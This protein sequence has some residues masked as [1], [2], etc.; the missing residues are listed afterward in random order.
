MRLKTILL[1]TTAVIV[2]V[3]AGVV[4][5]QVLGPQAAV[6]APVL[7]D[8]P[9]LKAMSRVSS[10]NALI[11]IPLQTIATAAEQAA[12]KNFVGTADNPVPQLLKNPDI[13]WSVARGPIAASNAQNALALTTAINGTLH[14]KGALSA[15]A[16]GAI[17]N[18]LGG[19]LGGNVAKQLG[20]INIQQFNAKADIA[21][22]VQA[23]A[24]PSLLPNWRIEPN[25][26][27]QVNLGD[28]ALSISGIRVNVPNQ[29]KPMIDNAVNQQL[30]QVQN[31][32][33]NDAT[34]E[35][36]ARVEWAKLCRSIPLQAAAGLDAMFL[37]LRPTRAVAAQPVVQGNQINMTIGL[38]AQTRITATQTKPDC[39]FP[40]AL[41]IA[42]QLT[43]RLNIAVPIDIPFTQINKLIEA[44]LVGK[45]F[46]ENGGGAAEVTVKKA[47]VAASGERLLVSLRVDGKE[48]KS[49]LGLGGE[50]DV[51]IWGKPVLDQKQQVMRLENIELAIESE[52]AFGL[53]GAAARAAMPYLQNA[54][55]ERATID[56]KPFA[57]DARK[58]IA[59]AIAD[60]KLDQNGV[61]ADPAVTDIRLAGIEYDNKTLRVI[62]EA[63][64]VIKVTV[65]KLPTL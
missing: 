26:A 21:G 8:L 17:N 45:T 10:V 40:A 50:A 25:I 27:A 2:T 57:A 54:L 65:N 24:R 5:M 13:N 15:N 47:T 33:R 28:T 1:V 60:I 55:A 36:V 51:H 32:V 46:P 7:A 34:L 9:P 29:I 11:A 52:A 12:P 6:K 39:P 16:Q 19:L 61:R 53:L 20:G 43:D 31:V 38:E 14:V 37:E 22:N 23:T 30:A 35:K 18:A 48:K 3:G 44:Q 64:G 59:A 58:Q 41:S 56:L 49:F 42:G 4:A 63:D 62:G